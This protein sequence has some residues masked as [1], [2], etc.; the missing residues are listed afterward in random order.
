M[1]RSNFANCQFDQIVNIDSVLSLPLLHGPERTVN[2][3][4]LILEEHY[5][6][7]SELE[8]DTLLS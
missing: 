8:I 1:N 7:I 2:Y 3:D 6:P 5:L 4:G